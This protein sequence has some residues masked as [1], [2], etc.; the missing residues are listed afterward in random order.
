MSHDKNL[1]P[2]PFTI[3]VIE[4]ITIWRWKPKEAFLPDPDDGNQ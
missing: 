3:K 4:I 1:L 2:I